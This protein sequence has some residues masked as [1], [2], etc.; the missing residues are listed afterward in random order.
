MVNLGG[1]KIHETF[2]ESTRSKIEINILKIGEKVR[3]KEANGG[4]EVATVQGGAGTGT[5]NRAILL[6]QWS[7]LLHGPKTIA[8]PSPEKSITGTIDQM[9]LVKN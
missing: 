5:E 4:K 8:Y 3:I 2:A 1:G 9:P 6:V 7:I